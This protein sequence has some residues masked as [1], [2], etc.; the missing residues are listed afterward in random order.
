MRIS[1]IPY[2][3]EYTPGCLFI[4]RH[5]GPGVKTRPAYISFSQ[6][7][8]RVISTIIS[9]TIM[10]SQ[11]SSDN[12]FVKSSVIRSHH[13]NKAIPFFFMAT[14]FSFWLH[15]S[16]ILFASTPNSRAVASLD[17]FSALATAFSLYVKS[18]DFLFCAIIA[19]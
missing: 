1:T 2:F 12:R 18:K 19:N 13:V 15:H 3:L 5:R 7:Y 11:G 8:V 16:Q 4:S 9:T 10:A 14:N 17:F 6:V